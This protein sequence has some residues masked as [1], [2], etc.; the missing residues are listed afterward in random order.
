MSRYLILWRRREVAQWP[1]NPTDYLKLMEMQWATIEGLQKKGDIK[2]FG[3]FTKGD[4]GYILGEGDGA[5]VFKDLVMFTHFY[6]FDV[7]EVVP[8][9]KGK[10]TMRSVLTLQI[11]AMKK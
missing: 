9:E 11:E 6:D 4:S 10:E 8:Y 7:S 3:W 1:T 5:T 2:E